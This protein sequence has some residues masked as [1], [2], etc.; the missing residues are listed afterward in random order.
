MLQMVEA[1]HARKPQPTTIDNWVQRVGNFASVPA[2]IRQLGADPAVILRDAG[3]APDALNDA[4]GCISYGGL[5]R[6]LREAADQTGCAHLGL[7]VGR[8]WHL[9]DL[10]LLGELMRNSATVGEALRI[11]SV[12]QHLNSEGG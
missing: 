2:L 11:L 5:G 9:S 4:E 7:L 12:Y 8:M 1:P 3:L 10:G 6:F